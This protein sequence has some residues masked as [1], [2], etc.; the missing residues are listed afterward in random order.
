MIQVG[1]P[2]VFSKQETFHAYQDVAVGAEYLENVTRMTSTQLPKIFG[3]RANV[4]L[5]TIAAA[6]H[7]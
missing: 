4:G 7:Q 3:N 5:G 2:L 1:V 6:V